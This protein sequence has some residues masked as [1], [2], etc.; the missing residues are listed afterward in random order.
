MNKK[1]IFS[2]VITL[3]N[4]ICIWMIVSNFIS[5][6]ATHFI[7]LVL[8]EG[9]LNKEN[10]LVSNFYN[11]L[12]F[13]ALFSIRYRWAKSAADFNFLQ[14][15]LTRH[16]YLFYSIFPLESNHGTTSSIRSKKT[17]LKYL[18]YLI[19]LELWNLHKMKK[20]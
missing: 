19:K 10:C 6:Y 16:L 4:W 5:N 15:L 7:I 12:K 14:D 8:L 20:K 18:R 13:P 1:R 3:R 11:V 9:K 2:P 17:N